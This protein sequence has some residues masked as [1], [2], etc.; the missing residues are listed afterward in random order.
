MLRALFTLLIL[1]WPLYSQAYVRSISQ[2][3]LPLFWPNPNLTIH[4]NP[5]NSSGL[6]DAQVSA[7][8]SG[9]FHSWS[10]PGTYASASYRQ[11]FPSGPGSDGINGV[12][13]GSSSNRNLGYGIVAMTEVYYYLSSGQ[14]VEADI[15]F[16]DQVFRFTANE[17]DTGRSIGGRTAIFLQDVA[18]HEAG[19]AF[20]LDHSI[21]N[22]SSLVYTAFS[23]QFQLNQ[24]DKTAI[25]TIYPTTGGGNFTGSVSGRNGGIFGAH[26]I[27]IHLPTGQAQAGA[28][29]NPDGTFRVGNL[30]PGPYALL[31][32]PYGADIGS[33]SRYFQNVDHNFCSR[34]P[35]RRRFYGPCG[36]NIVS[37]LDLQS[38]ASIPLGTLAPSCSQMGNPA[39]SPSSLA[40]AQE[41]SNSGGARFGTLRA[42]EAHYYR[43]R[44][45][46][47]E[48]L[49]RAFSYTLYSPMD[50]KVE[51]FDQNGQPLA[52][53]T[54]ID[55]V[56]NPMPGG[57]VNY[58]SSAEANVATGDYVVKVSA[59][60]QRLYSSLYPAGFSLLDTEGHYLLSLAVDGSY[61]TTGPSDMGACASVNNTRQRA[62]FRAPASTE[63]GEESPGGCGSLESGN[64]WSGGPLQVLVVALLLHLILKTRR[65]AL[66]RRRR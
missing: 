65:L 17:G 48:L 32:E 24:D 27:A 29:A 42:G 60:S 44:N 9:A 12:Y 59:A 54:S 38:G 41:I 15:T 50:V 18:T 53:A 8:M 13:F 47:G 55:N 35:F 2:T 11:T 66:V 57:Y 64:P 49:A 22:L 21:V 30:P 7:M 23:G 31:M 40:L 10:V 26:V 4:G 61:G 39:G 52:G 56:Q 34:A 33:I 37:V 43:V 16:N 58:D 3:G 14:I 45:V 63:D 28:L 51:I 46:S 25:R 62:S 5:R 36:S 1:L 20:G 6:S 19:H